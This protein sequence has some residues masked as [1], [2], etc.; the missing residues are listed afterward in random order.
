MHKSSFNNTNE[1]RRSSNDFEYF[2]NLSGKKFDLILNGQFT[3]ILYVNGL[4]VSKT[5][6]NDSCFR[7]FL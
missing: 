2:I 3:K 4:S 7:H 6:S 5:S 1:F